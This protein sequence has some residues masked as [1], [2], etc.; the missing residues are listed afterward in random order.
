M[1]VK[2]ENS[3]L[4][5]P[6]TI[7]TSGNTVIVRR[8]MVAVEATEEKPAHY[9][10]EEWQMTA[11]QYAIYEPMAKQLKEQEDALVELAEMISEV[12]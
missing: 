10:Y 9:V 11:E 4:V 3:D 7:E 1:W 5:M 6:E 12:V 2:V 8:H